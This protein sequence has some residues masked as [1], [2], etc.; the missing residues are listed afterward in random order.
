MNSSASLALIQM[1]TK[2]S[3]F[4]YANDNSDELLE[5]SECISCASPAYDPY[6]HACGVMRCAACSFA[7]DCSSGQ[8]WMHVSKIPLLKSQLEKIK[9]CCPE[10]SCAFIGTRAEYLQHKE[11]CGYK[12]LKCDS[13]SEMLPKKDIEAHLKECTPLPCPYCLNLV[14]PAELKSHEEDLSQCVGME[15]EFIRKMKHPLLA[16]LLKQPEPAPPLVESRRIC[17]ARGCQN[18]SG[19][20]VYQKQLS[21]LPKS[22]S[23]GIYSSYLLIGDFGMIELPTDQEKIPVCETCAEKVERAAR[24]VEYAKQMD[25]EIVHTEAEE[26][27]VKCLMEHYRSDDLTDAFYAQGLTWT[28]SKSNKEQ[29]IKKAIAEHRKGN[30]DFTYILRN[31]RQVYIDKEG[32]IQLKEKEN[33]AKLNSKTNKRKWEEDKE[34]KDKI[35]LSLGTRELYKLLRSRDIQVPKEW[36]KFEMV[37]RVAE[38]IKNKKMKMGEVEAAATVGIKEKLLQ[39][40]RTQLAKMARSNGIK[41]GDSGVYCSEIADLIIQESKKG[42]LD[43]DK[44]IETA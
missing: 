5:N 7:H 2:G 4:L 16:K 24:Y 30:F 42:N 9:V 33:P 31:I 12:L 23:M 44:M 1:S 8:E 25:T 15:E 35:M 34:L 19:S 14:R 41:F 10:D 13:C 38:E 26:E 18:L 37:D 17:R 21:L 3:D 27:L 43:I 22:G 6:I 39:F 40:N 11:D 29:F 20:Y 28:V 32:K 36:T